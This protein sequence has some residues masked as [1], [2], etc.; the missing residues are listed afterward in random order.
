MNDGQRQIQKT[1]SVDA[2]STATWA[3]IVG[4][5]PSME[6]PPEVGSHLNYPTL[7]E[8]YAGVSGSGGRDSSDRDSGGRDSSDRGSGDRGS[9]DRGS[10]ETFELSVSSSFPISSLRASASPWYPRQGDHKSWGNSSDAPSPRVGSGVHAAFNPIKKIQNFPCTRPSFAAVANQPTAFRFIRSSVPFFSA[11]HGVP[12]HG[13]SLS[14][15]A[16]TTTTEGAGAAI[17]GGGSSSS[18]GQLPPS[19]QRQRQRQQQPREQLRECEQFWRSQPDR[20]SPGRQQEDGQLQQQQQQQRR[21]QQLRRNRDVDDG[22]YSGNEGVGRRSSTEAAS[23]AHRDLPTARVRVRDDV[24]MGGALSG[25]DVGT[26][27]NGGD[28]DPGT[29]SS[30]RHTI[31]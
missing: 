6:V 9:G 5:A 19:S 17:G 24:V 2:G 11:A 1:D 22:Q 15:G 23:G 26:T 7:N 27:G 16:T 25:G 14:A 12:T 13:I 3:T 31:L 29:N 20:H 4:A 28:E 18:A 21:E 10:G 8:S 30:D